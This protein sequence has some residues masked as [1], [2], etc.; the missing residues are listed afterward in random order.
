[1][2]IDPEVKSRGT[3][4]IIILLFLSLVDKK[5]GFHR[6]YSSMCVMCNNLYTFIWKSSSVNYSIYWDF[7]PPED[8]H[9]LIDTCGDKSK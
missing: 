1:M 2:E 5:W 8:G 4:I 6:A 9:M 7:M 3:R